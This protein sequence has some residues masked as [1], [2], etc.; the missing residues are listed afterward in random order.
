MR[1]ML[2]RLLAGTA[3]GL[4]AL[5]V[6]LPGLPTVPFLILAA[7]AGGRGWPELEQRLLEHPH[8]GPSIQAWRSNR[9][10]PRKAKWLATVFIGI[11]LSVLFLVP[12]PALLRWLLLPFLAVVLLWLWYR[13]EA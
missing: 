6:A 13:P 8:Y 7:W 2:W 11:S 4:G 9:A 12:A 10:I 5:G 1:R 3:L